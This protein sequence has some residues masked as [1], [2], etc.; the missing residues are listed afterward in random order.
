[1]IA[2][3]QKWL[4]TSHTPITAMIATRCEPASNF[5]GIL[6][7]GY[8]NVRSKLDRYPTLRSD[9]VV[10]N[11]TNWPCAEMADLRQ[12][13][14]L[15]GIRDLEVH[16][17]EMTTLREN[18]ANNASSRRFACGLA[19]RACRAM[20]DK[21]SNKG[22]EMQSQREFWRRPDWRSLATKRGH[23]LHVGMNL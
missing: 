15:V 8:R 23:L 12:H 18:P 1:M 2:L 19:F 20:W 3:T 10:W 4:L 21:R 5:A 13:F 6:Y 17:G 16:P 11:W 7:E 22:S 14:G 9:F